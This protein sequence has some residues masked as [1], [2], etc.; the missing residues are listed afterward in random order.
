MLSAS[1]IFSRHAVDVVR[2]DQHG[3]VQLAGGAGE[4]GQDQHP[5][6]G[7]I[8]RRHI[9]LGDQVH[10]VMQRRHQPHLGGTIEARQ[11]GLRE[12]LVEVAYRHPI[13]VGVPAVD[14]PDQGGELGLERPVG[15]DLAARGNG[16]LQERD[17]PLQR[18]LRHQHAIESPDPIGDALGIIE[19]I[20]AQDQLRAVQALAQAGD[21]RTGSRLGGTRGEIIHADTDRKGRE[22]RFALARHDRIIGDTQG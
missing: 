18:R 3:G 7:R 5:G 14:L 12:A 2:I 22:L 13:H 16:D 15:C 19:P 10:A 11:G 4:F 21:L 17:L 20:D 9:F 8:L 1:E 6:I